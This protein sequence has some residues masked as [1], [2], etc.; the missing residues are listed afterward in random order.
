MVDIGSS[1]ESVSVHETKTY[2]GSFSGVPTKI[3]LN[4]VSVERGMSWISAVDVAMDH[5]ASDEGFYLSK[6]VRL[7]CCII[8]ACWHTSR[9]LLYLSFSDLPVLVM[10]HSQEGLLTYENYCSNNSETL[11]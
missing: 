2:S 7:V 6:M 10:S 5:D 11:T 3:S 4:K 9:L 8:L 1:G